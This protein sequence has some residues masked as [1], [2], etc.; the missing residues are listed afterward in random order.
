[1]TWNVLGIV[2]YDTEHEAVTRVLLEHGAKEVDT[3]EEYSMTALQV[4]S[5]EGHIKIVN[6]TA[7]ERW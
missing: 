1:M 4:T 3:K 7:R 2:V 5:P 6:F